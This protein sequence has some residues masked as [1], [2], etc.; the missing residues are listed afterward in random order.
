MV[1]WHTDQVD[2]G[3]QFV[4]AS[5]DAV[6]VAIKVDWYPREWSQARTQ[7]PVDLHNTTQRDNGIL[8]VVCYKADKKPA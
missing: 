7:Q 8:S 1:K 3:S 2:K 5:L 6:K 4:D